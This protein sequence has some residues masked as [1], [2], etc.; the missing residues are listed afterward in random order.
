MAYEV[1][2][3]QAVSGQ[4]YGEDEEDEYEVEDDEEGDL[5]IFSSSMASV[6]TKDTSVRR[7]G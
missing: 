6:K 1:E 4:Q 3:P 7:A 5:S 2:L